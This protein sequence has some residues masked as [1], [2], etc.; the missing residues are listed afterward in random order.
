MRFFLLLLCSWLS[1]P[2]SAQ[3][4][5]TELSPALRAHKQAQQITAVLR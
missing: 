4:A 1:I 2:V 5:L 3:P